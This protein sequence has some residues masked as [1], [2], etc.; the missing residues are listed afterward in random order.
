MSA[1]GLGFAR[2]FQRSGIL[3]LPGHPLRQC[4]APAGRQRSPDGFPE[5][6]YHPRLEKQM[7]RNLI[8]TSG[9]ILRY[10]LKMILVNSRR[11]HLCHPEWAG[12]SGQGSIRRSAR[13]DDRE[14]NGQFASPCDVAWKIDCD[15]DQMMSGLQKP[16]TSATFTCG[17]YDIEDQEVRCGL[18]L[19]SQ[20]PAVLATNGCGRVHIDPRRLSHHADER[21]LAP[22]ARR[23]RVE[24]A[25]TIAR[26]ATTL[27]CTPRHRF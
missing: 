23:Y 4:P 6:P 17:T 11:N 19:L 9:L 18:H 15:N 24:A 22:S 26:R 25:P 1:C 2:L 16:M 3:D 7:F 13:V 20:S 10:S 14:S 5:V 12:S 8:S 21:I 27:S